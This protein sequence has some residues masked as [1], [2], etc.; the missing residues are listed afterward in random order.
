MPSY[1]TLDLIADA[2]NPLLGLLWIALVLHAGSMRRWR[3]AAHRGLR[4]LLCLAVAYGLEHV[5]N[6][7]GLWPRLGL[8]YS[9]H[10]AV[11]MAMLATLW[12]TSRGAGW[13]ALATVALYLPL[14]LH[15]GYHGPG[16][17][18]STTLAVGLLLFPPAWRARRGLKPHDGTPV[19]AAA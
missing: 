14:M 16:D 19:H 2:H 15:Q 4:G 9:T 3:L 5:D 7:T 18:A 13:L 11:A 6:A 17:I 12:A 8:D 10:T 1:D